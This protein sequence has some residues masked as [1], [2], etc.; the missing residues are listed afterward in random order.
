MLSPYVVDIEEDLGGF[1][2][3]GHGL[4]GMAVTDKPEVGDGV[5]LVKIGTCDPEEVADHE[6]GGPGGKRSE[7]QSKT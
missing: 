5:E 4:E 7:R 3:P 1:P 6:V 2:D